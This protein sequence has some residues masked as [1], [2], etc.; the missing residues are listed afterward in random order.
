MRSAGLDALPVVD[1]ANAHELLGMV[2]FDDVLAVSPVSRAAL[3][4]SER[5][6]GRALDV[7][8]EGQRTGPITGRTT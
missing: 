8:I 7:A 1:R 5:K 2:T 6:A 3:V 4:H